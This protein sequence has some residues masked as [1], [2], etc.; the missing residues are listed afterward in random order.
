MVRR[1]AFV[2]PG[3]LSAATGGY[4]YDRQIIGGLRAQGW[5]VDVVNPG[6]GFPFP[7]DETMRQAT[8]MLLAI[9]SD[10]AV[11]I[12]GLA[13]GVMPDVAQRLSQTHCL[14][15]LVH[16]PLALELGLSAGQSGALAA[17]ERAALA[18]A[19]HVIVTSPATARTLSSDFGVAPDRI[20]VVLPGTGRA[21]ASPGST[22]GIVRLVAV[23]SVIP[24]KGFDV[25]ADALA[26]VKDLPWHL[27]IAGDTT[28]DA[29]TA[30]A[31]R[32]Q[33]VRLGLTDRIT[34]LGT[35][36][37]EALDRVYGASDAFVLASHYE[38]YGM[39]YAEALAHG[40]PVIGT[41]GGAIADTV[42]PQDGILV[43]PGHVDAL[44]KA[45]ATLIGDTNRRAQLAAGARTAATELPTW[46]QS[47]ALF[48]GALKCACTD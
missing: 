24:R 29:A 16:H 27:S 37:A 47:C 23:G 42:P 11:V 26:C 13:M 4:G 12:D 40:L 41:T 35:L 5:Q 31:L 15:A 10:M 1:L 2:V 28:R 46:P 44:A 38:G 34:M 43:E 33:I 3:D 25:L 14:V 39:A 48:S 21:P 7:T 17:L 22:D 36:S 9:P 30:T 8:E 20:T 32:E 6:D 45:L 19:R 18:A